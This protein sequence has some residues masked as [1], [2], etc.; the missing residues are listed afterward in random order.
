[1]DN[2]TRSQAH[3]KIPR[4]EETLALLEEMLGPENE[5]RINNF[6]D[7]LHPTIFLM[8]CARSGTTLLNQ[9]LV[10]SLDTSYPSNFLSRFYYAPYIGSLLQNLMHTYD[11]KNE[12]FGSV[13]SSN[14]FESNLGKTKG[15]LSPNEFWYFWRKHFEFPE[16]GSIDE[17]R[18]DKVKAELFAKNIYSIQHAFNKPIIMKGM[19]MNWNIP[20][21]SRLIKRSFF[22]FVERDIAF[23]AQSLLLSRQSFFEDKKK[24]YSFKPDEY[25]SLTSLEPEEQVVAQVRYTNDAIIKGLEEIGSTRFLKIQYSDFCQSPGAIL[26]QLSEATGVRIKEDIHIQSFTEERKIKVEQETWNKIIHYAEKYS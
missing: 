19:I 24:W 2:S 5:K 9:F 17:S 18:I 21:L 11:T 16:Y 7:P 10:S 26:N 15:P 4:V 1:M 3:K 12:L 20:F 14:L 6:S 22:I 8:G 23:N 25:S 13:T